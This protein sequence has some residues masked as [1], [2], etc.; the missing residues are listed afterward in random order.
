M[1][2]MRAK[3]EENRARP[4]YR[5]RVNFGEVTPEAKRDLAEMVDALDAMLVLGYRAK[6][7]DYEA[8]NEKLAEKAEAAALAIPRPV[9]TSCLTADI[10]GRQSNSTLLSFYPQH[11]GRKREHYGLHVSWVGPQQLHAQ[12]VEFTESG[13]YTL[14]DRYIEV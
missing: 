10:I 9:V 4:L 1:A 11:V 7:A 13:I 8:A 2:E 3:V 14:A 6:V 12:I 5:C